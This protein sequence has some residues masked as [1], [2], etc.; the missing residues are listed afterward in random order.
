M[1][2]LNF[3]PQW[4]IFTPKDKLAQFFESY[5]TLLELNLWTRTTPVYTKRDESEKVWTVILD[6]KREDGTSDIRTFNSRHVIQATG[7]SGKKNH[8]SIKGV[9]NF[10]GDRLCHS[11]EFPG[12]KENSQGKK[13]TVVGSCNSAHDIAQDFLEKG[14]DVTIVQRSSTHV[15]SSKDITELQRLHSRD[16]IRKMGRRLTMLTFYF[17]GCRPQSS[18]HIKSKLQSSRLNAIKKSWK[19]YIGQGSK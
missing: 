8:P 19:D 15:V 2:Y 4:P 17:T 9:E 10:K 11:S 1:P 7:H 13:A 18:R 14:Y 5:A 6:R 16:F 3:P 12:A